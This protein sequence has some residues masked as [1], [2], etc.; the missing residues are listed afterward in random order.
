MRAFDTSLD[1]IWLTRRFTASSATLVDEDV[2]RTDESDVQV[3]LLS[4]R[5]GQ[6]WLAQVAK[7]LATREA[8]CELSSGA[9]AETIDGTSDSLPSASESMD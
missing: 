5:A 7:D 6:P 4:R 2:P 8:G 1:Y 3:N 9:V